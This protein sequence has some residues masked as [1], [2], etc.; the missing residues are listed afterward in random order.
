[1]K[2]EEFLKDIKPENLSE[3][4]YRYD[5]T[6]ELINELAK[7]GTVWSQENIDRAIAE[8]RCFD[9]SVGD[10]QY[11]TAWKKDKEAQELELKINDGIEAMSEIEDVNDR[12][13]YYNE[14][15]IELYERRK[16]RQD[17]IKSHYDVLFYARYEGES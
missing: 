7:H 5:K 9:F 11:I 2:H 14:N 13:T 6:V 3:Y 16:A 4:I 17:E 10:V 1:M 8:T 15:V 12:L